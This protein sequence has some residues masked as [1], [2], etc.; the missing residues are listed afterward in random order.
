MT[1]FTRVEGDEATISIDVDR[2]LS[3]IN[4]NIYGG[5]TE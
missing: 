5:F 1:T 2:K 3:P 4:P